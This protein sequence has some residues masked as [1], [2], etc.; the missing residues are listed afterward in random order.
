MFQK[1][2]ESAYLESTSLLILMV[3]WRKPLIIIFL[4]TLISSFIF[5][6]EIFILPKYRSSVIFF[7]SATNSVSKALL[8]E[9]NSEKQDILAFGEEEQAEQMLQILNSDEIRELIM[10]N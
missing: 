7:P 10:K 5:S 2:R 9:S 4:I 6:G 3:N 8:E 1:A